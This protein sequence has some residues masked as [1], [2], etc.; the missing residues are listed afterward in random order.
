[1]AMADPFE[2]TPSS[3]ASYL[4]RWGPLAILLALALLV[5]GT[6]IHG[7]LS[8]S[9]IAE[10]RNGLK[11]LVGEH[12][13][14]AIT[15][16]GVVYVTV[17]ALSVP[18]A[19]LLTILGGFLFGWPVAGPVTVVAATAGATVIFLI[20]RSSFGD[21]LSRRAGPR[22]KRLAKGFRTNGFNYLLFLRLVPA[23]PFWMVNIAPALFNVKLST[24]VIA[25]LLG[26]IPATFAFSIL[27]AGLD[28]IIDAQ[29]TAY[30]AC[31]ATRGAG[32]CE[33]RLDPGALLTPE[34]VGAFAAIGVVALIPVLVRRLRARRLAGARE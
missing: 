14:L 23:F 33:F 27:G 17:V 3:S 26:I 25:T 1:M 6:G 10:H 21:L 9:T 8:L 32:A 28:S 24:Y 16:Y 12:W 7:Y 4:R 15:S 31:V 20:A 5:Y 19:A 13:L 22:L 29:R 30:E 2:T 18:G 34:I 11:E